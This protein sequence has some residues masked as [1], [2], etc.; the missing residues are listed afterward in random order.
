MFGL[1]N[2]VL[3]KV[4]ETLN[5]TSDNSI[6]KEIQKMIDVS[7]DNA[8]SSIREHTDEKISVCIQA[9]QIE[10]YDE[11]TNKFNEY[12]PLNEFIKLDDIVLRHDNLIEEIANSSI[13]RSKKV[14]DLEKKISSMNDKIESIYE[15]SSQSV[16]D[17]LNELKSEFEAKILKTREDVA[18]IIKTTNNEISDLNIQLDAFIDTVS[19]KLVELK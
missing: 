4:L 12:T 8:N 7:V 15:N 5:S 6:K 13:A 9:A 11:I 14:L 19:E 10:Y 1:K 18:K 16:K 17:E 2:Y 3:S